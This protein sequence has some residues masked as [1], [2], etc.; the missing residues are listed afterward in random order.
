MVKKYEIIFFLFSAAENFIFSWL[1]RHMNWTRMRKILSLKMDKE[2]NFVS[3]S[4]WIERE[5][6]HMFEPNAFLLC[7]HCPHIELLLYIS[8]IFLSLIL[9]F[10][11]RLFL[12]KFRWVEWNG[13]FDNWNSVNKKFSLKFFQLFILLRGHMPWTWLHQCSTSWVAI[14]FLELRV[15]AKKLKFP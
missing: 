15:S 7:F 10:S 5:E 1:N 9:I 3:V 4:E 2:G 8:F 14:I 12:A 13:A 6:N 11:L